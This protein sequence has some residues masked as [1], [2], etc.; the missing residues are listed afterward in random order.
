[1]LRETRTSNGKAFTLTAPEAHQ[2]LRK[3]APDV[4]KLS[5]SV[6]IS[7]EDEME[8]DILSSEY[9]DY[10]NKIRM[11]YHLFMAKNMLQMNSTHLLLRV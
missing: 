6:I 9:I 8:L 10:E 7:D 1:M 5:V 3:G 4:P 2:I 11:K